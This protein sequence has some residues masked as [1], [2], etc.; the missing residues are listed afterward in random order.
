MSYIL[1][2]TQVG[3]VAVTIDKASFVLTGE[4]VGYRQDKVVAISKYAMSFV[5]RAI[6]ATTTYVIGKSS[7]VITPFTLA[8]N[9]MSNVLVPMV[10]FVFTGR[11][12]VGTVVQSIAHTT[13]TFTGKSVKVSSICTLA[14]VELALSGKE[15]LIGMPETVTIDKVEIT[16]DGRTVKFHT[17]IHIDRGRIMTEGKEVDDD[18]QRGLTRLGASM[19]LE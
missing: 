1:L 15:V 12:P 3:G 17:D 8:S 6:K 13:L 7:L 11:T 5:G 14:K 19:R 16:L 10:E 4:T 18:L 9:M 2:D